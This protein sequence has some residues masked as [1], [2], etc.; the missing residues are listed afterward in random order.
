M[1]NAVQFKGGP[2]ILPY[3]GADT[4]AGRQVA[5]SLG[6][7][8]AIYGITRGATLV[9]VWL[10][11]RSGGVP[12]TDWAEQVLALWGTASTAAAALGLAVL[13][14]CGWLAWCGRLTASRKAWV[15]SAFVLV[16]LDL[17]G[18][19]LPHAVTFVERRG[20]G[21]GDVTLPF[22]LKQIS[23]TLAT[24]LRRAI[25][26]MAVLLVL[27][28]VWSSELRPTV[29]GLV[30]TVLVTAVASAAVV[31]FDIRAV[32]NMIVFL[33]TE[34]SQWPA[35]GTRQ[36]VHY[37]NVTV[38]AVAYGGQAI[39]AI[40][41]LVGRRHGPRLIGASCV[42]IIAAEVTQLVVG[43]GS[44]CLEYFGLVSTGLSSDNFGSLLGWWSSF[45]ADA[46]DSIGSAAAVLLVIRQPDVRALFR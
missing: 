46:A 42:V 17:T 24:S 14:A 36:L 16:V 2:S 8:C 45:A 25:L 43:A 6:L 33:T 10:R 34:W 15:T 11:A 26:P 13:A 20:L 22:W 12:A 21:N 4:A 32:A 1:A 35:A 40:L 31:V 7:L 38:T 23:Y 9:E 19:V 29:N 37:G 44:A 18:A 28:R 41:T 30:V 3:T 5:R 39:G 27:G